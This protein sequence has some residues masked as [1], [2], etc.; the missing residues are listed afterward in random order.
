MEA[1]NWAFAEADREWVP[2]G[3]DDK[4]LDSAAIV[5]GDPGRAVVAT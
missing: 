1:D 2:V 3:G 4:P 5:E